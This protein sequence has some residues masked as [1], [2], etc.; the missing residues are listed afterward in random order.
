[1]LEPNPSGDPVGSTG[2][3]RLF[4]SGVPTIGGELGSSGVSCVAP[5]VKEALGCPRSGQ[6]SNPVGNRL[7]F[8][9]Y[10]LT[11]THT[12]IYNILYVP[13]PIHVCRSTIAF[14]FKYSILCFLFPKYFPP[15]RC[16]NHISIASDEIRINTCNRMICIYI[17]KTYITYR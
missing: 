13:L 6:M 8:Y 12:H 9:I 10:A 11:H 14:L 3:Q 15:L 16:N 7:S 5:F 1:M 4:R 17:Y 2:S